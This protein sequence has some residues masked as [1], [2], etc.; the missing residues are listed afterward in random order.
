MAN[1]ATH[2]SDFRL[3]SWWTDTVQLTDANALVLLNKIYRENINLIKTKVKEYHFYNYWF[4]DTI[5]GQSE[6][7]LPKRDDTLNKA[8]CTKI[9]WVSVK[10]FNTDIDFTKLRPENHSNLPKDI[11][12]YN[13]NL[14]P[15][16]WF[17]TVEDNSYFIKPVPT[18][19]IVWWVRIYWI[20]DPANLALTSVETDVVIPLEYQDIIPLWMVYLY[21]KTRNLIAEKNDALNEYTR[22]QNKMI[23]WLSDRI[24]VPLESELPNLIHLQ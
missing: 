12:F 17:Y 11:D 13:K 5:I 1:V 7:G 19:I 16:N 6:Y 18:E 2:I 23:T 20:S 24:E 9:I 8:G 4:T 15:L 14:A 10:N 3:L 22:F 21:Y